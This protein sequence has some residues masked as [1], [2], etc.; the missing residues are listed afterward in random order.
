MAL[1]AELDFFGEAVRAFFVNMI[2]F[3]LISAEAGVFLEML[4]PVFLG[5]DLT[6]FFADF[7]M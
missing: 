7:G 6:L 5:E 2:V 3:D 1:L 4:L